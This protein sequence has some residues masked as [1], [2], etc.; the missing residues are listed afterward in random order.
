MLGLKSCDEGLGLEWKM[1]KRDWKDDTIKDNL[2]IEMSMWVCEFLDVVILDSL[3]LEY[4]DVL[5]PG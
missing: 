1:N 2:R 3:I 4:S 5:A